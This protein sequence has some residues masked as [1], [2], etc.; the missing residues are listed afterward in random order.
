GIQVDSDPEM[1]RV[2]LG[3]NPFA[4]YAEWCGNHPTP[5]FADI[6]GTVDPTDLPA[7]L[8]TGPLSCTGTEKVSGV[9]TA[10]ALVCAADVDTDT[11]TTYTAG[12][13]LTLTGTTFSMDTTGLQA[14]VTGVCPGGQSIRVIGS[15]GSVTCELDN[16]TTYTAGTGMILSGTTFS[17]NQSI[18]QRRVNGTC[19]AGNSIRVINSD[20]SVT[21]EVDTD[22]NTTYSAGTGLVLSATTFSANVSYLQRRVTGTCAVGSAIR[23]ISL[24]GTVI[25]EPVGTG[26]IEGVIAGLGLSGGGASGTPTISADITYLQR[27]VTGTCGINTAM[28][29]I[30]ADG[31]II[32]LPV[33][34]GDITAVGAGTGLT[35]GGTVGAVTINAD[36]TYLQRRVLSSC[37]VNSAIRSIGETGAVICQSMPDGD[38]TEVIAGTGLFGGGTSGAVTLQ[39]A[40]HAKIGSKYRS[41][42]AVTG[43]NYLMPIGNI[44]PPIFG[45]C[46][47][48]AS[49]WLDDLEPDDDGDTYTL[50]TARLTVGTG[51]YENDTSSAPQMWGR[52]G[53][54]ST[55]A[56]V[57]HAWSAFA[58]T[59]YRF[60]CYVTVPPDAA[61]D[62][63]H[64]RVGW[65]CH[66]N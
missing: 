24:T 53:S 37:P 25:C 6:T 41:D 12:T 60:G 18:F 58:S 64:C 32:C 43:G 33:Y 36:T 40:S 22:T 44:T 45:S 29:Q 52:G 13:G 39:L 27:R 9:D 1:G 59:S 23:I 48:T 17:V 20:G 38:I 51:T 65:I 2:L 30:N 55:T 4:G 66:P 49:A 5:D 50:K 57:N 15:D 34:N 26:D 7:G 21:C 28:V 61:G 14:R 56:S 11:D 62:T 47:V 16:D 46:L 19:G 54:V 63:I 3:S 31:T 35:G 8:V 42:V 10:G